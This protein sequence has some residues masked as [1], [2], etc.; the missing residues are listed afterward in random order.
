MEEETRPSVGGGGLQSV[1]LN[2]SDRNAL[3]SAQWSPDP[4]RNDRLIA[5][6]GASTPCRENPHRP[7]LP[8]TGS[9]AVTWRR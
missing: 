4:D 7:P 9:S 5:A 6:A 8:S 2:P 1:D 3:E